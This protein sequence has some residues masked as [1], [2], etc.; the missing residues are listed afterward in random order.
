MKILKKICTPY[1][2]LIKSL[3]I[4]FNPITLELIE[5]FFKDKCPYSAHFSH[6]GFGILG[7]INHKR[8]VSALD[9]SLFT[10]DLAHTLLIS[11]IQSAHSHWI[12]RPFTLDLPPF[13]LDLPPIHIGF[14]H[15]FT[16]DLGQLQYLVRTS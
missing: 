2:N 8:F 16:L 13:T 12:C 7:R 3:F 15:P 10:L 14:A 5:H 9:L 11:P 1:H 6:I 4:G